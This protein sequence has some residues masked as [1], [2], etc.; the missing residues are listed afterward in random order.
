[1]RSIKSSTILPIVSLVFLL[2][3]F[4][5]NVNAA[6]ATSGS[7][8]DNATWE[9]DSTTNTITI[10]GTGKI[11]DYMYTSVPSTINTKKT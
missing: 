2:L 1:M 9:Y 6:V 5:I 11:S 3:L 4:P 8:G 7:A 10:S